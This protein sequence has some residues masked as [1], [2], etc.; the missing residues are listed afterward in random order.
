MA[1]KVAVI[2]RTKDR[3]LLLERAL[4]SVLAQTYDDFVHVIVNDGGA[5]EEVNSLLDRYEREYAGRLVRVHHDSS[6]GME[7]AS[8]SGIK[9]CA[10][11]F[12]T[13]HDD[14]DAWHPEFLE[15]T[16]RSFDKSPSSVK[17][18]VS[19]VEQIFE[20]IKGHEVKELWR[21]DFDPWLNSV[22]L[23]AI[24]EINKFMPISFIY[25]R[26]ALEE[27]GYYDEELPVCGD[28]DF[29]IRFLSKF[30]VAVLRENLAYYYI[31][32]SSDSSS[33]GNTVTEGKD[34]HIFYRDVIVNKYIRAEIEAGRMSLGEL[35]AAGDYFHR[36]GGN[37]WR[38]VQVLER[39]KKNKFVHKAR[40]VLRV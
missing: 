9:A 14:D 33:Y 40:K 6:V 11:D 23:P 1:G 31:R 19:H 5:K 27:V 7:A 12:V 29:N 18:V 4:K 39:F 3:N 8:N 35:V 38:L 15:K 25:K 20:E 34:K 32:E 13:I 30:D 22:S 26:E 10:S 24:T 21:Q 16:I 28:W 37:M 36:I 2:T 17:G